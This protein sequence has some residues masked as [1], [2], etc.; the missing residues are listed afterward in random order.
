[1]QSCAAVAWPWATSCGGGAHGRVLC[2]VVWLSWLLCGH[3]CVW[4]E[5][6]SRVV[7]FVNLG[8]SW[9]RFVMLSVVGSS[10]V[11]DISY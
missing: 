1:M 11:P 3:A 8:V 5:H 4:A 9:L 7:W 6:D 10:F 2:V